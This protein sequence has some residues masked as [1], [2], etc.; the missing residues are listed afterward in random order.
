MKLFLLGIDT[1]AYTASVGVVDREGKVIADRRRPLPVPQGEKGLRQQT[2]V[3]HHVQ[4]LPQLLTEVF[5]EVPPKG[6][7]AVGAST[8]PRPVEGSYMPVFTVSQG[9]GLVLAS[10]LEVP[11]FPTSHQEGHLEAGL[12]SAGWDP[13]GA[14]FIA[15]HL[16]GGTSEI[17]KVEEKKEGFVITKLGGTLDLHAGQLVDRIGVLLGLPFPAGP[18]LERLA[19]GVREKAVS[20]T[21]AVRG[22]NFSFSGPASQ[23]ERLYRQG[24]PPEQIA[25]AVEQCIANTLERVLRRAISLTGI[26]DVLLVGGVAANCYIRERLR[27]RLEHRAVGAR[28]HFASPLYSSDNA[29]G[30][31]LMAKRKFFSAG[32]QG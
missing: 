5:R 4:F 23:A 27:Q 9:M 8:R 16:S 19:Q 28:L 32:I 29:V 18:H 17:L 25:R 24:V 30:V 3:F 10:A 21:S 26:R 13:R 22:L 11:F 20:L 31:A 2:A 15:V 6:I 1:S 7:A 14:P 12:W